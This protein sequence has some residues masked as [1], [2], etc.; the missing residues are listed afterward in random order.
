MTDIPPPV[1]DS[2]EGWISSDRIPRIP[3]Q[4]LAR[5]EA[6]AFLEY[7]FSAIARRP[8]PLSLREGAGVARYLKALA[9]E[10]QPGPIRALLGRLADVIWGTLLQHAPFAIA[11]KRV[12]V[13]FFEAHADTYLA[14]FKAAGFDIEGVLKHLRDSPTPT[15]HTGRSKPPGLL[16]AHLSVQSDVAAQLKDDISERIYAAYHALRRAGIHGARGRI[17]EALNSQ[18]L[19]TRARGGTDTRWGASEVYERVKQYEARWRQ[20]SP[21]GQSD[22]S[23]EYWRDTVVDRWLFLFHSRQV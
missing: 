5:A 12:A 23:V 21:A 3:R 9:A 13:E 1:D 14:G 22:A 18:G 16:S 7:L 15:R 10:T 19:R 11:P 2:S 4:D 17:A 6:G 8:R 20:R